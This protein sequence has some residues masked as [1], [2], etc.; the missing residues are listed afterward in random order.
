MQPSAVKIVLQMQQV[1]RVNTDYTCIQLR[2]V[3]QK[4]KQAGDKKTAA[5]TEY[6]TMDSF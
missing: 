1:L 6:D 2:S 3:Y 4:G 5:N